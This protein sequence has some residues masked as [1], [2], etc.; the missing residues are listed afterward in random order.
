TTTGPAIGVGTIT[1]NGVRFIHSFGGSNFFA[2]ANAGNGSMTGIQ[3]TAVGPGDLQSNTSG[4][5]NAA[6]GTAALAFNTSGS[7]N[8]ATGYTALQLNTSGGSNTANGGSAL[9]FNTT[10]GQNTAS[11]VNSLF[12]NNGNDNTAGGVG[13]LSG[14]T[15]GNDNTAFGF[16]AGAANTVGSDNTFLGSGANAA[17]GNLTNATAIGWN[18]TVATSN[19]IVLGNTGASTKVGIGINNPASILDVSGSTNIAGTTTINTG[20]ANLTSIGNSAAVTGQRLLVNGL[21]DAVAGDAL[22]NAHW[23]LQDNGDLIVGGMTKTNSLVLSPF[24]L[25]SVVFIGA[26]GQLTQDNGNFFWDNV[27]KR[28]GIGNAAPLYQLDVTGT[29][30]FSGAMLADNT[31]TVTALFTANGGSVL[32][33]GATVNGGGTINNGTTLNN[34]TTSATDDW[35]TTAPNNTG[36]VIHTRQISQ[37]P[38]PGGHIPITS[39]A[40]AGPYNINALNDYLVICVNAANGNVNLP[41]PAANPGKVYVVKKAGAGNVTVGGGGGNI[42][43]AAAFVLNAAN[44]V[45]AFTSDGAN[46]WIISN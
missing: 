42:D 35:V 39:Q 13:S 44:Q 30:H 4:M 46:W 11:G 34:L 25:G 2:G 24:T 6:L 41:A 3:N 20:V 29:S 18:S 38:F 23:D 33:A 15:S 43:G 31:L 26:G 45:T 37:L 17:A 5:Q 22:G 1:Q 14:N 36:G 16:Q 10:G 40:L 8:T 27:N 19:A 7:G 9:F 12:S 32:N 21:V 28:L